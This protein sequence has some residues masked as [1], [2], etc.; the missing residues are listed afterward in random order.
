MERPSRGPG[1]PGPTRN[2]A[3]EQGSHVHGKGCGRRAQQEGPC[4]ELEAVLCTR[5]SSEDAQENSRLCGSGRAGRHAGFTPTSSPAAGKGHT[6]PDPLQRQAALDSHPGPAPRRAQGRMGQAADRA[7]PSLPASKPL[8]TL[9]TKG[10]GR[11]PC[12]A[13]KGIAEVAS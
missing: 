10:R 9:D 7:Q 13:K 11:G 6:A 8:G 3:P 2:I 5:N 12:L 4:Q 1:G